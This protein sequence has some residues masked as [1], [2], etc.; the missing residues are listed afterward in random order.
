MLPEADRIRIQHMLELDLGHEA[1]DFLSGFSA[2]DLAQDR[3][4]ALSIVKCI[5]I[6]GEAVSDGTTYKATQ[7]G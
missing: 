7:R 6:I 3:M 4:R 2:E 5:E 1:R